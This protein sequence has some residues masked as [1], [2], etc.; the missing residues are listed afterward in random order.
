MEEMLP[1]TV[2][3]GEMSKMRMWDGNGEEQERLVR[4]KESEFLREIIPK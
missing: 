3:Y 1:Y 2:V 4:E